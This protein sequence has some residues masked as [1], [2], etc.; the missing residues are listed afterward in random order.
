[1]QADRCGEIGVHIHHVKDDEVGQGLEHF[2]R[3][4]KSKQRRVRA[5][6]WG[7]RPCLC[8][9]RRKGPSTRTHSTKVVT[10]GRVICHSGRPATSL[11][12]INVKTKDLTACAL[13]CMSCPCRSGFSRVVPVALVPGTRV[14]ISDPSGATA[15]YLCF[16]RILLPSCPHS[17]PACQPHP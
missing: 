11:H 5:I 7:L 4:K 9:Q 3:S 1:M 2:V 13:L 16:H 15:S 14:A 17:P 10:H 8:T 12:R 6:G